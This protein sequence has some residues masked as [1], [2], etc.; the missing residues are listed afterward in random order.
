MFNPLKP[1]PSSLLSQTPTWG[2]AQ[3][4]PNSNSQTTVEIVVFQQGKKKGV[5]SSLQVPFTIFVEKPMAI[6][7]HIQKKA[8]YR[9][10]PADMML[11]RCEPSKGSDGI[12]RSWA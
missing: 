2:D 3:K 8:W 10:F 9:P 4:S 6:F 11:L 7:F 5:G 1:Y 12:F